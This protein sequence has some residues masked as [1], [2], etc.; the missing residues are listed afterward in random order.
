[1]NFT[2][3]SG[4]D[5]SKSSQWSFSSEILPYKSQLTEKIDAQR[6]RKP[7]KYIK[8][9]GSDIFIKPWDGGYHPIPGVSESS[10]DSSLYVA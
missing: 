5:G 2:F 4:W 7:K 1:L 9:S 8:N 6:A 10:G 3:L